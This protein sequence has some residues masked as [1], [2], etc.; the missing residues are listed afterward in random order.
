MVGEM[1][2]KEGFPG[3]Y[4]LDQESLV[5]L[6]DFLADAH[7]G[8]YAIL[9]QASTG[10]YDGSL[11]SSMITLFQGYEVEVPAGEM[12]TYYKDEPLYADPNSS[13]DAQ[14]YTIS[15]VSGDQAVLSDA[16]ETAKE[17]PV[18][19]LTPLVVYNPTDQDKTFLLIPTGEDPEGTMTFYNGFKGT[20]TDMTTEDTETNGPWNMA[21]GTAYYAFNG[22]AFVY[23]RTALPVGANKCWLEMANATSRN[24]RLVFGDATGINGAYGA[25]GTNETNEWYDLSGRRVTKPAKKGVYIQNGRK[26]V[27]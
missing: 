14:L 20:L 25:N 17:T 3:Y 26:V 19:S 8:R 1:V 27:K 12:I 7:L 21:E 18:H 2:E 22:K 11:S 24:I 16:I 9:A 5:P 10:D 4:S 6:A 15:S 23:V 13:A